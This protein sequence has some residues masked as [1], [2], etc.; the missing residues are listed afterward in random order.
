M[1][2]KKIWVASKV[3]GWELGDHL[4]EGGDRTVTVMCS[5]GEKRVPVADTFR[6]DATHFAILDDLCCMSYLHEAPL[7][8]SLRRRFGQDTIYTNAGD[9]LISVNP[10]KRIPGLY[11]NPLRYLDLPEDGD[12]DSSSTAP[13]VFKIANYALMRMLF[14]QQL[15]SSQDTPNDQSIVVSG[16]SGAGKTE[17]SKQVMNF[18]IAADSQ[19]A[20]QPSHQDQDQQLESEADRLGDSIRAVLMKSNVIFEAFGNAKTVRNDNS[21]RFGKYIKLQYSAQHRLSSAYTETFLLEK[22]RLMAVGAN[23]RNYHV[24]YTLL[25]SAPEEVRVPLAL[26]QPPASFRMLVDGN[27]AVG[28]SPADGLFDDLQTALVTVGLTAEEVAGLWRVL[29]ALLHI[30][31]LSC[32]AKDETPVA[33][34][35]EEMAALHLHDGNVQIDSPTIPID[36]LAEL[37]GVSSS[38]FRARLTTQRVKVSTRRSVTIKRLNNLDV[39]NNI[40]ALVKWMYS[41]LFSWL[42]AKVNQAHTHAATFLGARFIGILD[43]FGFEILQTNS[44]EQL[45]IN[46][47]NE[48]LQQQFNEFVFDR[49]QALYAAE[50]LDWTTI[51]YKDN[52]HVIDLIGKKPSGLL[53]IL[54]G[55][56]MLNRGAADEAAL[57]ASFNS[58]HASS[59]AFERSRFTDGRFTVKH[60]AGDV[61][62]NVHG[63]LDKNND[64]LQEDLLELMICS[65]DAFVRNAIVC[66]SMGEPGTEGEAGF[67][68]D[69]SSAVRMLKE[70]SRKM[71]ATGRRASLAAPEGGGKKLA[72]TV[73]VSFQFRSQ[74]DLLMATLRATAPHYIKCIKPN[75]AKSA[76]IFDGA[77]VLEQLRYSGALEVV[78]IRRDGYPVA[79]P[80]LQFYETFAMLAWGRGWT[81]P[82]ECDEVQAKEYAETLC[83]EVLRGNKTAYQLGHSKVFMKSE[84]YEAMHAAIERFL[85][86]KLAPLQALLR[87]RIAQRIYRTKRASA[88]LLQSCARMTA[89]RR[90]YRIVMA[91]AIAARETARRAAEE[92]RRAAEAARVAAL[93]A[94]AARIHSLHDAARAGDSR[95][96]A[97]LLALH[98]LDA[99]TLDDRRAHCSLLH[100]AAAGG[101]VAT[102]R[103]LTSLTAEEVR[104]VDRDGNGAA[105]HALLGLRPNCLDMLRHLMQLHQQLPPQGGVTPEEVDLPHLRGGAVRELRCGWLSKRGESNVWRRRYVKLTTEALMYFRSPSDRLPRDSLSFSKQNA[106]R[107]SRDR[108]RPLAID[109]F[110]L[111]STSS[112]VKGRQR[113][114]LMADSEQE[115]QI[116]MNLLQAAAGVIPP[117]LQGCKEVV[118]EVHRSAFLATKNRNRDSLLHTLCLAA[119]ASEEVRQGSTCTSEEVLAVAAWLLAARDNNS[120]PHNANGLTALQLA[121]SLQLQDLAALLAAQGSDPSAHT[122][123]GAGAG[124]RTSLSLSPSVAFQLQ[125]KASYEAYSRDSAAAQRFLAAPP[126]LHGFHYLTLLCLWSAVPR[127]AHAWPADQGRP[128]LRIGIMGA[129]QLCPV[130]S[131]RS[132]EGQQHWLW[133]SAFHLPFPLDGLAE[134]EGDGAVLL[135]E[136]VH[137]LRGGGKEVE[138]VLGSH[139]LALSKRGIASGVLSLPLTT[140]SSPQE[141]HSTLLAELSISRAS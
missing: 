32:S 38:T 97:Q 18:L 137:L 122:L 100:S 120:D 109:C 21:S 62:Y 83:K 106:L 64:S 4:T 77:L 118:E 94:I 76:A 45:C 25:A 92:A 8:D 36:A 115:V 85:G 48:R 81:P 124:V 44:F 6:S 58:T 74:L 113:V 56:G 125:L 79:L 61:T 140:T 132:A 128:F 65:T 3:H 52:Q 49:E 96:V 27:G 134:T 53:N 16:E 17:A 119:A 105:Q 19:L 87:K 47:T 130:H 22:S 2:A 91:D 69:T 129:A 99:N 63:F 104:R 84:A 31:N 37:L 126:R 93:A 14:G 26:C 40:A 33:E 60:F 43:I 110:L 116:W 11:E 9:V 51:P 101:D 102:V 71:A 138:V 67:V 78:R 117:P 98:P 20:S 50:G 114:S 136:A 39:Q 135:I 111:H 10:Y 75:G 24:F 66:L 127:T 30:G 72:A 34:V 12:I 131:L 108:D 112:G 29:G 107:V 88:V 1:S 95:T 59:A 139:R 133:L 42:L 82:A 68:P 7:L 55:Q 46:Y 80:F 54:E 103:L 123:G 15:S 28:A 89:A 86:D 5:D 90:R 13:H 35:E 73:T 57:L 121:S 41:S 70:P 141:V 23:E